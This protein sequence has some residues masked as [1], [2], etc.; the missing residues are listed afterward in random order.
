MNTDEIAVV[1][2]EIAPR[3]LAESWDNVGWQVRIPG[4]KVSGILISLDVTPDV[5]EEAVSSGCN[6]V[7]AHHP[8]L[9][10]PISSLDVATPLG[11]MIER[12]LRHRVS[13]WAA[14]TNLDVVPG[15]TSFA[16][17]RALGLEDL[18][19]LS[20]VDRPGY[21]GATLG[22]GAVGSLPGEMSTAEIARAAAKMVSSPV[23]Q[24]AGQS[25]R[26]HS[27]VAV[28]GGSGGSFIPAVLGC[29]ATLF[30]TADVRYH[31]AQDAVA[32]GLDLVVLDHF[33]TE[34]PVLESVGAWLL[35][36]L[37]DLP[38]H[39]ATAPSTPW[40]IVEP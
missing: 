30:I 15:G 14:H 31:E 9:F 18:A 32:R 35:G 37:P 3:S 25:G 12:L 10:R 23:C 34:Y 5:I 38:V 39:V 13:V 4:E 1:L 2:E 24:M 16:L 29:D 17:G 6:L 28:M 7:F 8:S 22:F 20:P 11:A 36:R 26:R 21:G 33:A 19:V 40:V 27:R